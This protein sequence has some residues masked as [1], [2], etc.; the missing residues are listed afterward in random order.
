M[1]RS[2]RTLLGGTATLVAGAVAFALSA[3]S[4]HESAAPKTKSTA[5]PT[6]KPASV[7]QATSRPK[8]GPAAGPNARPRQK[9]S[10][11]KP[12][13]RPVPTRPARPRVA[14]HSV[15][16]RPDGLSL[17]AQA[18]GRRLAIYGRPRATRTSLLLPNPDGNGT[19]RVVLVDS[20]HRRWVRVYLPT[21]PNGAVGWVRRR[22]VRV[23]PNPYRV[24]VYI[25]R[26]QL[27]LWKEH[28]LVL[29]AKTVVG[30]PDTPTP[31]GMYYVVELLRPPDPHGSYGPFSF[32]ISAHSN[33][34]KRF[35]GGDGRVG[36]HG[37][38]APWLLG[39]SVSHGCLRVR[40]DTIRR[41]A[42][43]LPLGT[44]VLIRS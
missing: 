13:P 34:L 3:C 22:A 39:R 6:S 23:L 24:V 43:V 10:K 5:A 30:A 20:T 35:A 26:H 16:W 4:G 38:D 7:P 11:G 41:L 18:R 33:V 36:I 2:R 25:R 42:R 9:A 8:P 15:P 27:E 44:P 32:G 28:R 12:K 31:R 14:G 21:R 19:P 1:R 29:R 40:N 17:V 37:T